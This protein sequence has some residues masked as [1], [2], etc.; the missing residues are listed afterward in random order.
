MLHVRSPEEGSGQ[1]RT[2]PECSQL[3]PREKQAA[4]GTPE[5]ALAAAI[6]RRGPFWPS[7]ER[8][9]EALLLIVSQ[10]PKDVY[11]QK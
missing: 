7:P 11:T 4:C 1:A 5:E 8:P 10:S 3:F 9:V 6:G 2:V